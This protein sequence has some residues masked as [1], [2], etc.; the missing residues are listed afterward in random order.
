[1][2]WTVSEWVY[3]KLIFGQRDSNKVRIGA[4]DP[5]VFWR[6]IRAVGILQR[7]G[8]R[9]LHSNLVS[10]EVLDLL[11]LPKSEDLELIEDAQLD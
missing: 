3:Q 1:M 2:I 9:S 7:R 5:M 10:E 4:G 8:L 11:D 6:M